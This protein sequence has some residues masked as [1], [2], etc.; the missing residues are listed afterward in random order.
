MWCNYD[1]NFTKT[2]DFECI[3]C[4]A[5]VAF[6][7]LFLAIWNILVPLARD[8][9]RRYIHR[10]YVIC[11]ATRMKY[12]FAFLYPNGFPPD[13]LREFVVVD[14]EYPL[15]GCCGVFVEPKKDPSPPKPSTPCSL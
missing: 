5:M 1:N 13:E 11:F 9:K 12:S 6:M 4:S 14:V 8:N 15:V 7:L 2:V 10:G 3:P